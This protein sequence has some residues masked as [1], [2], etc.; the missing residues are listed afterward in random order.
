MNIKNRLINFGID[1][2]DLYYNED[3]NFVRYKYWDQF[4]Y[5]LLQY[6]PELKKQEI[7]EDPDCGKLYL[8][9]IKKG[10]INEGINWM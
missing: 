5:K 9:K 3:L 8:Y 2:E 10:I 1:A 4:P 6:F 7:D